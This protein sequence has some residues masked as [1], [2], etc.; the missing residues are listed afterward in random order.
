MIVSRRA[1][2]EGRRLFRACQVNGLLDED[3]VRQTV[4]HL[5]AAGQRNSPATLAHFL[6]L[7]R[8]DRAR[9]SANVES[10]APLPMDLQANIL[11]GL[12]NLYG[13]G[14]RAEFSRNPA[15]IGGMRIQV[16]SDLYDS[17]VLGRLVALEKRF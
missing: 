17:S 11:A 1:K 2:Q 3:R 4:Q 9:H 6:R 10:A 14:I 16:G 5:V 15:L 12:T 13:P 7:V 8:I